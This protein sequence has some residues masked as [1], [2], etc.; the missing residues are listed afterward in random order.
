MSDDL[1]RIDQFAERLREL[2]TGKAFHKMQ[3]QVFNAIFRDGK[4]RIFI[5]KGR[6]GG[7]TECILYP[8]AR[9]LVTG[10]AKAVYIIGPTQTQQAEIIWHN[11]RIHKFIPQAWQ[12]E[13]MESQYRVRLPNESFIKVEGADD[14]EAARGWEAD[15]FIWDEFKDHNPISL[16][17]CYPNVA[18]RDAIW[19]V[20]GSPP[21]N[22]DSHYYKLEEQIKNDPDWAF[23]HWT[24]WDNTFLPGGDE[25]LAK[26][27]AKFYARGEWDLWESEWE[28][29]YVFSGQNKALPNF[30]PDKHCVPLELITSK[31]SLDKKKLRWVTVIDPGYATCFAVLFAAYNPFTSE[32]FIFDEIYS[33]DRTQNGVVDMLP[34]IEARQKTLFGGDWEMVYDSAALGFAT[35]AYAWAKSKGKKLTLIPTVKQKDDEDAFFRIINASLHREGRVLIA[36][37][38]K[39]LRWEADCYE[40]DEKGKYPNMNNHLLDCWR[41]LYKYLGYTLDQTA[42]QIVTV[43]NE[44]RVHTLKDEMENIKRINDFIGYGGFDPESLTK[45]FLH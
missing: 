43:N 13:F 12:P 9:L 38:C 3:K 11:R 41:Y 21:R 19:I 42:Q 7:G 23:F 4:K 26:E 6:K 32:I 1:F 28:A 29:R 39:K 45:G 15:L 27:K 10:P 37:R 40:I 30:N 22:R 2:H 25:F 35:D 33:T 8:A 20:L 24:A 44:P 16:Q 36:S 31:L 5:R 14:P 34:T 17:N 18:A